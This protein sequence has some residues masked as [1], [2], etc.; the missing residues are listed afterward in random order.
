MFQAHR[1]YLTR[2]LLSPDVKH[3]A[4]CSAD[5]TAKIW[6]L[7]QAYPPAVAAAETAASRPNNTNGAATPTPPSNGVPNGN[8]VGSSTTTVPQPTRSTSTDLAASDFSMV[9]SAAS[10]NPLLNPNQNQHQ[11]QQ[12]NPF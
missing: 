5:H 10:L 4:T 7:D 9:S 8:G 1:D 11:Q 6:N 3:L 2:V 12:S